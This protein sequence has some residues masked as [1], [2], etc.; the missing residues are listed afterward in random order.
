MEVSNTG[1]LELDRDSDRWT[2]L[3]VRGGG[4]SRQ[5]EHSVRIVRMINIRPEIGNQI[6][7][8]KGS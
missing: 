7:F 8:S 1:A 6:K 3:C 2:P 4:V 5:V